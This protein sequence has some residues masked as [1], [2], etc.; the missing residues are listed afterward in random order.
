MTADLV[1]F[2]RARLNEDERAARAATPGPWCDSGGYVTDIDQHGNSRVQVTEFG[3][4][5]EDGQGS[6]PQGQADSAHIAR[7]DPTRVLREVESGRRTLRAHDKWCEGRCE[8]KYPEGGFDAAHYWNLKV[9]AEVYAD[10]PDY[11]P[12]WRP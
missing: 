12:E 5:D 9:R 3:T 10:H 4:Q 6:G 1:Q 11:R 7:H 8:A 2:L